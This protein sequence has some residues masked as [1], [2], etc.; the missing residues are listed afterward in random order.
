MS[1]ILKTLG[2]SEGDSVLEVG[3]G[4]GFLAREM[5]KKHDYKGVDYSEP[6]I[7]KHEKLFPE[8]DVR[9][10][11]GNDLPFKDNEFDY[12]FCFGVYQYLPSSEYAYDMIVE[13][14]R[15]AKKGIL[16][17]DLKEEATREQHLPCLKLRMESL[18]FTLCESFYEGVDDCSRYNAFYIKEY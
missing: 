9:C 3:C 2:V 15:V 17:G 8:H 13:M 5:S 18:G 10:A 12:C 7:G 4:A 1:G 6:I 11:Q 14:K 16:L